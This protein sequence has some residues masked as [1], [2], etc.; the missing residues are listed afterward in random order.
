MSA[1][2]TRLVH[3]NAGIS[4]HPIS[5]HKH[6]HKFMVQVAKTLGVIQRHEQSLVQLNGHCG[7]NFILRFP[8]VRKCPQQIVHAFK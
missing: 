2:L 8:A 3:T 1:Y 7:N 4:F 5:S 6:V